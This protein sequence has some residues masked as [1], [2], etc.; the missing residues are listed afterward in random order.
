MSYVLNKKMDERN[1]VVKPPSS[2][3]S[4]QWCANVNYFAVQLE[5]SNQM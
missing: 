5:K 3:Q 4:F 2:F 1:D